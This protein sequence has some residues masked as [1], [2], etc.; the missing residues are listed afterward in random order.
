MFE[1]NRISIINFLNQK[2][3]LHF[4]LWENNEKVIKLRYAN[5]SHL[6]LEFISVDFLDESQ[7][8]IIKKDLENKFIFPRAVNKSN[9]YELIKIENNKN[10]K[11]KYII[12]SYKILGTN[13]ILNLKLE[14]P[15]IMNN[16]DIKDVV[17]KETFSNFQFIEKI[18]KKLI[19][20]SGEYKIDS[21]LYIPKG[22]E[23][24]I[25][26]GT[27]LDITKNSKIISESMISL[28]GSKNNQ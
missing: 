10:L 11:F 12:L 24:I 17:K 3:H 5:A 8:L 1:N 18:D 21:D 13:K 6:P 7:N 14:D 20:S 27:I 19:I 15:K 25:E 2:D 28:T 4:T 9:S 26:A 22:Y 16:E 23:F